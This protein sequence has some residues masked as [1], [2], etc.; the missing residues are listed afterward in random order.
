RPSVSR[1]T[2]TTRRLSSSM[3]ARIRRR[4]RRRETPGAC[5]RLRVAGR[6][7]FVELDAHLGEVR[8]ALD[9]QARI[10]PRAEPALQD[11]HVL[12]SELPKLLGDPRARGLVGGGAIRHN[13]LCRVELEAAD[14]AVELLRSQADRPGN[15]ERQRLVRV[16]P[17]HVEDDWLLAAFTELDDLR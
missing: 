6:E 11:P 7:G 14:A 17:A 8:P 3:L 9:G 4:A 15:L 16:A 12:E 2:P 13:G 1:S 5:S 10:G